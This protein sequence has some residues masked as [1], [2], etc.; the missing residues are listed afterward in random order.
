MVRV[1]RRDTLDL[2]GSIHL[3]ATAAGRLR[4]NLLALLF[5]FIAFLKG[6]DA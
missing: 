5:G 2:A 4:P 6:Q 3:E 1:F